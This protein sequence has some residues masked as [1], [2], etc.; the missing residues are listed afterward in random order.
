MDS[1]FDFYSFTLM[2]VS[3]GLFVVRYLRDDPPIYPYLIIACTCYVGNVLGEAGGGLFAMVL[4][5]A[6]SFSFLGA[7]LFPRWR[8]MS[9]KKRSQDA[10]P[11]SSPAAAPRT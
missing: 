8:S 4:L 7:L 2:L 6:A 10:K 3:I 5:V 11:D 9:S 1:I